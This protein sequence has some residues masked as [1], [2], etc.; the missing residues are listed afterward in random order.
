MKILQSARPALKRIT[1]NPIL[2][3]PRVKECLNARS[4]E[5]RAYPD[6]GE[7]SEVR[8]V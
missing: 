3:V 1:L 4:E 8:K 2:E 5:I 7:I 6:V